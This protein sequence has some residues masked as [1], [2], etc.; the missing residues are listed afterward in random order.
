MKEEYE[1]TKKHLEGLCISKTIDEYTK[2]TI[3]EMSNK[4]LEHLARKY[5]NV[6]ERV[7]D[8]MGGQVLDYEAKRIRNEGIEKGIEIVKS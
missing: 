4:V 8:V 1:H 7:K 6:K 2:R 3:E 5:E